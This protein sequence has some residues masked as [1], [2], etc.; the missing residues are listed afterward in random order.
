VYWLIGTSGQNILQDLTLAVG[1]IAFEYLRSREQQTR[2]I[3]IIATFIWIEFLFF[4]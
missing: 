4:A 3:K 2:E 1:L